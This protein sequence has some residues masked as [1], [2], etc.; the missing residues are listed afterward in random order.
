MNQLTIGNSLLVA[1]VG[2]AVVFLGLCILIGLIWVLAKATESNLKVLHEFRLENVDEL[3][4]G[5]VI[6]ADTF[7]EGDKVELQLNVYQED[8]IYVKMYNFLKNALEAACAG[9]GFEGNVTLKMVADDDYYNT[10]Y[11]GM[12][13]IIFTTWGGAAYSPYTTLYECY[14]DAADGTGNQMELGYDTSKIN[15]TIVADGVTYTAP[16]QTWALWA[17]SSDPNCVIKSE[18]GTTQLKEFAA[19]DAA[20]KAMFYGKLEY[21]YLAFFTTT[22]IYYR[23]TASMISQKGDYAVKQYVD[24]VGFGGLQF[25]TFNYTDSAWAEYVSSGNLKY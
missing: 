18:D 15:V 21:A 3:N 5:D 6:K 12:T 22:P 1:V 7:K 2:I 19:Y 24:L 20:T 16:L 8:E 11:S 4:V 13:D 25:Y 10:M 14:C 23:S 9:T 17:D